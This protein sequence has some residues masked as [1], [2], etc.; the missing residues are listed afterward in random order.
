MSSETIKY[1][2]A[3]AKVRAMYG[4]RLRREDFEQIA[5]MKSVPEVAAF[6]RNQPLWGGA[7]DA[8][9]V[10]TLSRDKLEHILK[11]HFLLTY[12]RLFGYVEREEQALLRFPV[13]M[14]ENEEI[15]RFMRLAMN[16]RAD[17]YTYDLPAYF[18]HYS[19]IHYERLSAAVTYDDMLGAVRGTEFYESLVHIRPEDGGFPTYL[20]VETVVRRYNFRSRCRLAEKKGGKA[21]A[22][23]REAIGVQADWINILLIMRFLENYQCLIPNITTY[24]LPGGAHLDAAD[25]RVLYSAES[26]GKMRE[27]LFRH[28][29]YGRFLRERQDLGMHMEILARLYQQ[30]FFRKHIVME[31]PSLFT[32]VAFYHLFD[33]ELRNLIHSVE[34]VRYRLTP[35]ETAYFLVFQ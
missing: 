5:G 9:D 31:M 29:R 8:V 34:C 11:R 2:A 25:L 21:G 3:A 18:N 12:L 13:L 20:E 35:E 30:R 26:T 19:K 1:G 17:R 28:K 24:L 7:L 27:L 22:L 4:K 33:N 15:M 10:N 6:L 16:G 23:L 14:V 32:P